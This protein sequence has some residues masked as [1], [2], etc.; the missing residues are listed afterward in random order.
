MY[1][2]SDKR[3]KKTETKACTDTCHGHFKRGGIDYTAERPKQQR[4]VKQI[5]KYRAA[6]KVCN[7]LQ[8][9]LPAPFQ[10][11]GEYRN[12]IMIPPFF[13]QRHT[14]KHNPNIGVTRDFLGKKK[15]LAPCP[16]KQLQSY[17][18]THKTEHKGTDPFFDVI[19]TVS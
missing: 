1:Q 9:S 6:Q 10:E 19:K 3:Q 18:E 7:K 12:C 15:G 5:Q 14:Q 17:R 13:S 8:S 16:G 11:Q 4:P 2:P